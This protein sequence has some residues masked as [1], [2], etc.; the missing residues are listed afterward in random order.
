M[1]AGFSTLTTDNQG[2]LHLVLLQMLATLQWLHGFVGVEFQGLSDYTKPWRTGALSQ[3]LL[4]LSSAL[5]MFF[6]YKE[7][8]AHDMGRF[9]RQMER[10]RKV[11]HQ[12]ACIILITCGVFVSDKQT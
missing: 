9:L 3:Q 8:K 1:L 11:G 10:L 5:V 2:G 6:R 7:V 4:A 12:I